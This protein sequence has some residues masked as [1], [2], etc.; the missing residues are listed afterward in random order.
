MRVVGHDPTTLIVG[1]R[2]VR[3]NA[4]QCQHGINSA[5]AQR[6]IDLETGRG[7]RDD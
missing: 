6:V 1:G 7:A 2:I 3:E 5:I 4:G